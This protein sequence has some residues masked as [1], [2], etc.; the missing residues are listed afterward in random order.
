MAKGSIGRAASR[1]AMAPCARVKNADTRARMADECPGAA[2]SATR[3]S[4]SAAEGT[5]A[6]D[7][8]APASKR[9]YPQGYK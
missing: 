5:E 4:E 3:P 9:A 6:A 7:L 8:L 2:D 1:S